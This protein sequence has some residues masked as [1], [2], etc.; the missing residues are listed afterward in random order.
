[1]NIILFDDMGRINLLPL[2]YTRPCGNLRLGI[3]T[4]DE[5]WK[6]L[7]K[8]SVSFLS[9]DYLS[10][11]FPVN[12][13]K[14]NFYINGRVIAN[15]TLIKEI[16]NLSNGEGI[17]G[18]DE[19]EII[20][21]RSSKAFLDNSEFLSELEFTK[22]SSEFTMVNY[23]YDLFTLND[24]EIRSDFKLLT[25]NKKSQALSA[26]NTLIGDD[27]F[28]EEGAYVEASTLNS[29]E[30]PIYIGKN[31]QILEGN[32]IRGPLALCDHATLKMGAKIYGATTIGPYCKIGGEV[33]N[34]IFQS[35]S[36]K[37]H[38]GFLGNSVI[39]EWCNLG[40]D[41]NS[42][43]L[44]NNYAPVK[45]W[46]YETK[47]FTNT[48]K[49]FCGLIMGD[50]SKC[51]INTMF[52]TGTVVGVSANIYGA[53]FPRNFIPSFTWG[54]ATGFSTYAIGKAFETAK[55]VMERRSIELNDIE[56]DILKHIFEASSEHRFWEN[57]PMNV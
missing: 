20:A 35:Y 6:L 13:T 3:L 56:K 47:R 18:K 9:Q 57:K 38:D 33:S 46:N 36:N 52:N 7:A 53:A 39:G 51:G 34:V 16:Q 8:A 49:Q 31:A 45:L 28:V 17:T 10:L 55:K 48:G 2:C 19:N 24:Q 32:L 4:L 21:F 14:D 43:N 41:T 29:K 12:F 40:A 42:S 11:K 37:G 23:S 1:M 30:G 26:T 27:V 25:K 44:K 15:P 22:C 54:G 50:H 5:K